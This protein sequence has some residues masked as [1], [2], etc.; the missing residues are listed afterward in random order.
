M[1]IA[2]SCNRFESKSNFHNSTESYDCY[3]DY[4]PLRFCAAYTAPLSNNFTSECVAVLISEGSCNLGTKVQNAED[5]L[6]LTETVVDYDFVRIL[7]IAGFFES[8]DSALEA[9]AME[10]DD[11]DAFAVLRQPTGR[12]NDLVVDVVVQRGKGFADDPPRVSLVVGDEILDV[13]Q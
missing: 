4:D 6:N 5:W 3:L 9:V 7:I 10:S 12:I 1:K 11:E 13:L 8:Y 2:A